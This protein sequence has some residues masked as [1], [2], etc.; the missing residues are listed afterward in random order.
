M[1]VEGTSLV[2]TPISQHPR[3]GWAET[4]R[5]LAE[6]GDDALVWPDFPNE[7]D[8]DCRW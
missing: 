2:I 1:R 4:S 7:A 5:E 3:A 6:S 8:S